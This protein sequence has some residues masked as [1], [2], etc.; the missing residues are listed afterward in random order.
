MHPHKVRQLTSIVVLPTRPPVAQ[1]VGDDGAE[2][3]EEVWPAATLADVDDTCSRVEPLDVEE[4][5]SGAGT[6]DVDEVFSVVE[7]AGVNG[8]CSDD[9]LSADGTLR[10]GGSADEVVRGGK[11]R[12]GKSVGR[13]GS[14]AKADE[15]LAP[16]EVFSVRVSVAGEL[17][18][19]LTEEVSIELC[20]G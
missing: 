4:A 10:V 18:F 12:V 20:V 8:T 15:R 13:L 14:E 16:R 6:V 17:E 11:S 2:T 7:M 3:V 5:C 9:E 1:I 19:G